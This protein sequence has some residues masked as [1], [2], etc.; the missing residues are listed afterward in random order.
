MAL[1]HSF[2]WLST[3]LGIVCYTVMLTYM[4]ISQC[5]AIVIFVKV[6]EEARASQVIQW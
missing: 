2:L 5:G 1:F 4:L 6:C 3:F